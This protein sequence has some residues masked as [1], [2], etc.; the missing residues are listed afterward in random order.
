MKRGNCEKRNEWIILEGWK[1]GGR[2]TWTGKTRK[3]SDR[4][5]EMEKEILGGSRVKNKSRRESCQESCIKSRQKS[6]RESRLD[7]WQDFSR[8]PSV[9][10]RVLDRIICTT[11]GKTISET[12]FFTREQIEKNG[13]C[14]L[15]KRELM[16]GRGLCNT[17]KGIHGIKL[18]TTTLK[19]RTL[20][21]YLYTKFQFDRPDNSWD[22][23][24]WIL[25]TLN[26][27]TLEH[28]HV[29]DVFRK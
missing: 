6:Y 26:T 24:I 22:T 3:S 8:S 28:A 19:K 11:F 5:L 13:K 9:S 16:Y 23:D 17:W 20:Q 1:L 29:R 12:R 21:L 15:T 2:M 7:S 10:P 14:E 4:F 18:T 27:R 25:R